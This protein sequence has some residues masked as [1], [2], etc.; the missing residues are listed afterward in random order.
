[1]VIE[2]FFVV[3]LF[4]HEKVKDESFDVFKI[5]RIAAELVHELSHFINVLKLFGKRLGNVELLVIHFLLQ[6]IHFVQKEDERNGAEN[7]I[8]DYRVKDV[9]GLLQAVNSSVLQQDL[10]ETIQQ[11]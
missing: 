6:K 3:S 7:A 4:R 1:M 5:C 9:S 10:K 8:V 11:K 2:R